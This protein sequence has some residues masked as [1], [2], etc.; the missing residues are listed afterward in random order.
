M[1][2]K[3]NRT[4]IGAGLVATAAAGAAAFL[5][6]RKM[7]QSD[8]EEIISDAPPHVLRG[9]ARPDDENARLVGKTVTIGRPR[10][11]L[12]DVWQDFTRFPQFMEN[13]KSVDRLDENRSRWR[14]KGPAGSEV[15]LVTRSG[16]FGL[17]ENVGTLK[18][19]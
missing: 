13:V 2:D 14:I 4:L 11:D 3:P 9:S 7:Q 1:P 6:G 18:P 19:K 10:Q 15:R 12:F 17:Y 5:W 8:N 16:R